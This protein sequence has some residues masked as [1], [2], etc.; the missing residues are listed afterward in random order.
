MSFLDQQADESDSPEVIAKKVISEAIPTEAAPAAS[1]LDAQVAGLDT[2]TE[3]EPQ[4]TLP[5]QPQQEPQSDFEALQQQTT[6]FSVGNLIKNNAAEIGDTLQNM[7]RANKNAIRGLMK[8]P[9]GVVQAVLAGVD[10]VWG[11]VADP[12]GADPEIRT[13]FEDQFTKS[14]NDTFK[15]QAATKRANWAEAAAVDSFETAAQILPSMFI[16]T[17]TLLGAVGVGGLEGATQFQDGDSSRAT[18]AALGVTGG[19]IG[20]GLSRSVDFFTDLGGFMSKGMTRDEA[21]RKLAEG[22]ADSADTGVDMK[23]SQLIGSEHAAKVEGFAEGSAQ[24]RELTKNAANERLTKIQDHFTTLVDKL[25]PRPDNRFFGDRVAAGY[26]KAITGLQSARSAQG[27]VDFL[28]AD[29]QAGGIPIV[30]TDNLLA[31]LDDVIEKFDGDTVRTY[32]AMKSFLNQLERTKESLAD[33]G[34]DARRMTIKEFQGLMAAHG[35]VQK[36]TGGLLSTSPGHDGYANGRIMQ[37][38]RDDLD[39]AVESGLPGVD[40]LRVARDNWATA[41]DKIDDVTSHSLAKLFGSDK[42]PAPEDIENVFSRLHP[43]Q[44]TS[45]M[46]VLKDV[47]PGIHGATQR[48]WLSE[49]M[50]KGVKAGSN[51]FGDV[52]FNPDA[53]LKMLKDEKHFKAIFPDAR[54]RG[55]VESGIRVLKRLMTGAKQEGGGLAPAVREAAGVALSLD[56]TFMARMIA[57]QVMPGKLSKILLTKEGVDALRVIA[58]PNRA[59]AV[60][61]KAVTTIER[62]GSDGGNEK[63]QE[64][65]DGR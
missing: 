53:A 2:A 60:L 36:G 23:F 59:P 19:T 54:D 30:K 48:F 57:G 1:F 46:K 55:Q 64:A 22:M 27:K 31:A 10:A 29:K 25:D 61:A 9:G 41:S 65:D 21:Q 47:D 56:G 39:E 11:A 49:A 50:A 28:A 40:L 63:L 34:T 3:P 17:R 20:H 4:A 37:A 62:L 16:P 26:T 7:N 12:R 33:V 51:K 58:K 6:Q 43:T 24:G 44:L 14:F 8:V 32:P 15:V 5:V 13:N 35:Q 18:S 45:A 52:S 42:M 38:L